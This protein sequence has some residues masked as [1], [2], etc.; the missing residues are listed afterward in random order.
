MRTPVNA[1]RNVRL[2]TPGASTEELF[3]YAETLLIPDDERPEDDPDAPP[4]GFTP[5]RDFIVVTSF[6]RKEV[7]RLASGAEAEWEI[8]R[9]AGGALFAE[10]KEGSAWGAS[11]ESESEDDEEADE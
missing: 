9:A 2:F 1:N 10:K 8:V 7:Q 11:A 4:A 3:V 6:P 5:P